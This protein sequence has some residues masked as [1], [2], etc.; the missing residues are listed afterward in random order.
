VRASGQQT[1][2]DQMTA[3]LD[4]RVKEEQK[5]VGEGNKI[6]FERFMDIYTDALRRLKAETRRP[7]DPTVD[8]HGEVQD[9][10]EVRRPFIAPNNEAVSH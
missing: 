7:T 6:P 10:V 2:E 1:I 5:R 9:F 3:Y 8:K 4:T